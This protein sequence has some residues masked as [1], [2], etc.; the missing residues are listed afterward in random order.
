LRQQDQVSNALRI[1]ARLYGID[2]AA[3]VLVPMVAL[4]N[5]S[6]ADMRKAQRNRPIVGDPICHRP[7]GALNGA[8]AVGVNVLACGLDQLVIAQ[9]T[10][11]RELVPNRN[12]EMTLLER[13][14][15]KGDYRSGAA[16][17]ATSTWMMREDWG[18]EKKRD[19]ASGQ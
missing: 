19:D 14:R 9:A 15:G 13:R 6:A 8:D 11:S 4:A 16:G 5:V 18:D 17:I 10:E 2:G 12:R 7:V 3:V 1:A